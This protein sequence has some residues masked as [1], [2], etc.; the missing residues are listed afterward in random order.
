MIVALV[1]V[2]IL[3]VLLC[4]NMKGGKCGL[5]ENFSSGGFSTITGL[6]NNN[7]ASYSLPASG[8][9]SGGTFT[10]GPVLF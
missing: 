1:V 4:M 7:R 6:S 2:L 9:F 10:V 5:S 8:G 3:I